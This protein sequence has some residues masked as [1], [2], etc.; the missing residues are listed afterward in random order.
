MTQLVQTD[1]GLDGV[2][3]NLLD[4]VALDPLDWVGLDHLNWPGG[5]PL[6]VDWSGLNQDC[7]GYNVTSWFPAVVPERLGYNNPL[8]ID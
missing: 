7:L 8:R 6:V 4:W 1:L 3:G 5:D 2:L